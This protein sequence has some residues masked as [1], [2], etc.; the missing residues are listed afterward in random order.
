MGS[1]AR[2]FLDAGDHERQ[3]VDFDWGSG[4]FFKAV[5]VGRDF[6]LNGDPARFQAML[7]HSDAV[8]DAGLPE[9]SGLSLV[10][11]RGLPECGARVFTR[12]VWADGA[13][14]DLDCLFAAGAAVERLENDLFGI[15]LGV[16]RDSSGSG[17]WQGVVECFYRLQR[18]AAIQITPPCRWFS[19]KACRAADVRPAAES[20]A[21]IVLNS[22]I[23]EQHRQRQEAPG[24]LLP[25]RSA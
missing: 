13:A 6:E 12:A 16:G 3:Q 23:P 19:V 20:A 11:E 9:G 2:R 22:S 8:E 14:A 7:W 25:A 17:D 4:D 18:S 24:M 15:A 10:L 21:A 1:H 5:Q